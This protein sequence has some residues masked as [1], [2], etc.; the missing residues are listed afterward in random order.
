MKRIVFL[1][2]ITVLLTTCMLPQVRKDPVVKIA[3]DIYPGVTG[4]Y[5]APLAAVN[6]KLYIAAADEI[7]GKELWV[8]DGINDPT[9][10]YDIRPGIFAFS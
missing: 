6:N 2:I 1:F 5:A 4:S 9:L 8:Y 3:F 7:H 10:V